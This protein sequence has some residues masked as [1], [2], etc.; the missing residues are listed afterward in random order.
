VAQIEELNEELKVEN[1]RY[2][3]QKRGWLRI[4]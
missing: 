4:W 2:V 1:L 3:A